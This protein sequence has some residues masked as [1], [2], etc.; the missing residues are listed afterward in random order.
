KNTFD[1]AI[2][3]V[4]GAGKSSLVNALRGLSDFAEGTAQ[5]DVIERTTPPKAY[6]YPTFPHVTLWDLPGIGTSSFKGEEYLEKVNYH[7]YDFF[8]IV[9]SNRFTVYDIQ[10]SRAVQAMGKK[11]FYVCSKMDISIQNE[12]MNPGFNEETTCQKIRNYCL[13]NL[14]EAGISFPEVFLVSSWYREK[15]DFPFL[16]RALENLMEEFRR[17]GSVA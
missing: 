3:G 10:L 16:Q 4:S 2:T 1:V 7:Q 12:K 9:A 5:A 11:L 8:L 6:L 14:V 15:F 17:H 13:S